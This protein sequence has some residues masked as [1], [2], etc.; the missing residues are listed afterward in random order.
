MPIVDYLTIGCYRKGALDKFLAE[1]RKMIG[2]PVSYVRK[3]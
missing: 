1:A 2:V 3:L